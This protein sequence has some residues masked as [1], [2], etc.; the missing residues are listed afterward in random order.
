MI[1]FFSSGS[2][3]AI[4]LTPLIRRL[5][6]ALQKKTGSVPLHSIPVSAAAII[7]KKGKVVLQKK[8]KKGIDKCKT[9]D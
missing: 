5:A 2:F 1:E 8:Y 9:I 3:F 4:P 7:L 6:D